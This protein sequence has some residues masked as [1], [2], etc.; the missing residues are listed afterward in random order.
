MNQALA[1][2]WSMVNGTHGM[3]TELLDSLTDADLSFTPGGQAMTLG[4]LIKEFGEIEQSY[5][6]SLAAHTQNFDY[7]N[8]EAGLD[9]HMDRL[10]AWLKA[11]DGKMQTTLDAMSETDLQKPIDRGSFS[12]NVDTQLQI[13]LQALLI[14]FGKATI[15]F[16]A[17]SKPLPGSTLAWIG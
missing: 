8:P 17:M 12:V 11:L 10:K 4:A 9:T 16:R 14:F 7:R 3:R 15:Y 13:Y 1:E 6:D 5:I 2:T